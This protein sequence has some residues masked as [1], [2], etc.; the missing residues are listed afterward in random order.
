MATAT[1]KRPPA[2]KNGAAATKPTAEAAPKVE[3]RPL[4][5]QVV[6]VPI[7]GTAELI[8]HNWSEKAKR[9][10]LDKQMNPGAR[11]K[12]D[13][14]DPQADYEASLYK[15]PG[16]GYGFPA[17]GFK[18]AIVGG[19]R[20]FDSLPMT[21]A[22]IAIRVLGVGPQALVPIEGTPYMREDMVRLETGVADIRYRG[23]FPEWAC[24][25]RI[26]YNAS[27]MTLASLINLVNG[28]GQG[29]VG[30]WRP[31]APKS[32]SGTYGTFEVVG[33]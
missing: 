30:E 22:K 12:K 10:M 27:L 8:V 21:Q 6:E 9:Q 32:N 31:S 23:A 17:P 3:L 33:Q 11:A 20:L 14:K 25:L 26:A 15:L 28:A 24:T 19:C 1:R 29:G 5:L 18:A 7:V 16:G 4:D 13:P 2:S